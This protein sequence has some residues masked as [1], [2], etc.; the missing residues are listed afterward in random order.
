MRGGNHISAGSAIVVHS[1]DKEAPAAF[2]GILA[3]LDY[4]AFDVIGHLC[5]FLFFFGFEGGSPRQ[6]RSGRGHTG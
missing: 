1:L 2:F 4:S 5:S 3:D 6:P